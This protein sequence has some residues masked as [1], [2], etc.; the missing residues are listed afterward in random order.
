MEQFFKLPDSDD[1]NLYD[2][3]PPPLDQQFGI[4]PLGTLK[5]L[6]SHD[7]ASSIVGIAMGNA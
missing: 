2:N 5:T 3:N 4:R 1:L 7:I 6:S